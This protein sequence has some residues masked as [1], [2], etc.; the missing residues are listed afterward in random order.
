ML[1]PGLARKSAKLQRS[2]AANLDHVV[3]PTAS[4][5][6]AGKPLK[7]EIQ[8]AAKGHLAVD[9]QDFPVVTKGQPQDAKTMAPRGHRAIFAYVPA[10]ADQGR[11]G[12]SKQAQT[13]DP[14]VADEHRDT[15]ACARDEAIPKTCADDVVTDPIRLEQAL[16]LRVV[17][18]GKHRRERCTTVAQV[19]HA[20]PAYRVK[21]L[22]KFE[23]GQGP[24]GAVSW[25]V[26][27]P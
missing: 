23:V 3:T 16:A 15:R 19:A 26:A 13:P 4:A 10:R 18:G 14:V 25:R 20:I 24:R 9:G 7:R 17:D 12:T 22:G 11:P 27:S 21:A 6:F 1:R 8:A 5:P 2:G